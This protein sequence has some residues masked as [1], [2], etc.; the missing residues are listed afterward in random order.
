MEFSLGTTMPVMLSQIAA[1]FMMMAVGAACY[2]AKFVPDDGAKAL[3]NLT[4]YV[5]TPAVIIRALAISFDSEVL[6][7]V[8]SVALLTCVLTVA[9]IAVAHF[10]Y[11]FSGNRV[12]QMGIII[13]N[14]GFMGIPLVEHV[15]GEDYVIYV[16]TVIATQTVFVWTYCVW[17]FTQDRSTVSLKKVATNPVIV[18]I[19]LG[20]VLFVLP[21]ELSGPLESFVDGM[22]NLNTG[23]GMLL[24]G[25][26]LAQ[27]DLR[28]LVRTRSIYKASFL[29]LIVASAVC[30]AIIV[31][32]PMPVACKVSMLIAYVTPCGATASIFAQLFGG[33]YRFGAGLA[34]I[35][36]L[37]SLVTM[38]IMLM[39]GMALL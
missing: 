15:V 38:P 13:S 22:A 31:A 1:M 35:S 9:T 25:I 2:K 21:F 11:G 28:S 20:A 30:I 8:V 29:R 6:A 37:L 12:A 33:D 4:C 26:Y 34:T 16:S 17:F 39:A 36:T 32:W 19:A 24:L 10:A 23:L 18:S 3:A 14:V 7:N 27:S 5:S